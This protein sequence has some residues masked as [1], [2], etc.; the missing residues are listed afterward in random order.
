MDENRHGGIWAAF[1]TALSLGLLAGCGGGQMASDAAALRRSA[2]L[3]SASLSA[4][5]AANALMDVAEVRYYS[6]FWHDGTAVPTQTSGPFAY[7]YYPGP[8][9]YLGVVIVADQGY[10]VGGVYVMGGS[11]GSGHTYVGQSANFLSLVDAAS[12]GGDNGCYALAERDTQGSQSL[13]VNEL[14]GSVTGTRTTERLVG[15]LAEF[16]GQQARELAITTTSQTIQNG[17]TSTSTVAD[18]FYSAVTGPGELAE[19]GYTGTSSSGAGSSAYS[20]TYTAYY[21]PVHVSLLYRLAVGESTYETRTTHTSAVATAG[22]VTGPVSSSTSI[23]KTVITYVGRETV[24]VPAGTYETCKFEYASPPVVSPPISGI[25]NTSW[26][27]VGTGITVKQTTAYRGSSLASS[28]TRATSV[29][30][31]YQPL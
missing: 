30:Y 7:R 9:T 22:G 12:A 1:A 31:N 29:I 25:V 8:G 11:F 3:A 2:P 19:Y 17:N 4:L 10:P 18:K 13:V 16:R 20:A 24:T 26:V 5:D 6:Y 23:R 28:V 15:P 21:E 27:I 14:S